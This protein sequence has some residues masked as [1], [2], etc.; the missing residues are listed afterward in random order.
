MEVLDRGMFRDLISNTG[1]ETLYT[2]RC[3]VYY[4]VENRNVPT[5][6]KETC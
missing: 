1:T 6:G 5:I 3:M 4:S 2:L